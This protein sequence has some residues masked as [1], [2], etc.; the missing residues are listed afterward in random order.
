MKALLELPEE[1]KD[2][3]TIKLV[4]FPQENFFQYKSVKVRSTCLHFLQWEYLLKRG[5]RKNEIEIDFLKK[6]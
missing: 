1:L 6:S 4:T 5:P 3:V 2:I